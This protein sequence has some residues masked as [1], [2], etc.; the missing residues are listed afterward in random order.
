MSV[1]KTID[2]ISD[3]ILKEDDLKHLESR[4]GVKL[5]QD[6]KIFMMLHNG[7]KPT[8][9]VFNFVERGAQTSAAVRRFFALDDSHKFYSLNKHI[10]I[11]HGRHPPW[12]VPVACDS[13]GNL[14]LLECADEHHGSV[15]FWDHENE[16]TSGSRQNLPLICRSFDE[17]LSLLAPKA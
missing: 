15:F 14:T 9:S 3:V 17:F 16:G 6:H 10:S 8:A 7:G 5:P 12:M 1:V 13:F 4:R 2:P 11:Y